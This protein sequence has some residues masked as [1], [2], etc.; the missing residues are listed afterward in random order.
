MSLHL[1]LIAVLLG[2]T[3]WASLVH[4]A[5]RDITR[6][7]FGSCAKQDLPQPIWHAVV[8]QTPDAF[9]M[10]GDNIY[11]DTQDIRALRSKYAQLG[12]K[13]AFQ[14]A[15]KAMPF[16]ATWDDHDYG[17]D[18]AGAEY[19]FKAASQ[20][21]FLDFWGVPVDSPARTQE[22]IYS[23]AILGTG[24]HRV[25]IIM[26]DTRYF[27]SS[28]T[29]KFGRYVP[30][31][32]PGSTMLGEAQWNWLA[33]ELKKPA[34]V[35]IIASSI[36]FASSDHGYETWG[37]MPYEKQRLLDLIAE[38]QAKGVLIVSGDRHFAEISQIPATHTLYPIYDFTSSGL[39]GSRDPTNE[40]NPYRIAPESPYTG[41]NF[42]TITVI[43][44]GLHGPQL[45][46]Q[47][48]DLEGAAVT[49]TYIPLI[50]L[51]YDTTVLPM[52]EDPAS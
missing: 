2:S 18:D 27:R 4:A 8:A 20:Q 50:D 6:I 1:R 46:L 51:R 26:L 7:A 36:Q 24:E 37:N 25:Q 32:N 15:R 17:Q 33:R 9:L 42:G 43:W 48:H 41:T 13:P 21:A 39:T 5:D 16:F 40:L 52:T 45:E 28:L 49:R 47:I 34:E 23:S 12:A 14:K 29:R 19:P 35:R 30:N 38:T 3:L 22:G 44:E 10:I 31:W 11:A